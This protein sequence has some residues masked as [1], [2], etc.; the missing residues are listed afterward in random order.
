MPNYEFECDRC[1]AVVE[2]HIPLCD[3]V[4]IGDPVVLDD[5][6]DFDCEAEGECCKGGPQTFK[7]IWGTPNL[8]SRMNMRRTGI[9]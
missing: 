9:L 6:E 4:Q 5:V 8:I 2:R 7:R 1:N 3:D